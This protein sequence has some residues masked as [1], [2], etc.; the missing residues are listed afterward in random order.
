MSRFV[1]S[2]LGTDEAAP[3]H[4][5]QQ[6]WGKGVRTVSGGSQPPPQHLGQF[7]SR[8]TEKCPG[9]A[10]QGRGRGHSVRTVVQPNVE[11][12][13][14]KGREKHT[15]SQPSSSGARLPG[16]SDLL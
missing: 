13:V 3:F 5:V 9:A 11:E 4:Q 8:V 1:Q 14:V 10:S 16:L 2:D 12:V 6:P 15:H 7:G